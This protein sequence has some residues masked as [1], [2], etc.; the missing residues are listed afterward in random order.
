MS[1]LLC[2]SLIFNMFLYCEQPK[3]MSPEDVKQAKQRIN[4]MKK[5]VAEKMDT[6]MIASQPSAVYDKYKAKPVQKLNLIEPVKSRVYGKKTA[7]NKIVVLSDFACGHCIT[8][9]KELKARID[10]N[11]DLVN[12]TYVFYPLDRVC[13]PYSK[14][15]LSDYS[16]ISTKLALCAEKQGKVWKAMDFLYENQRLGNAKDVKTIQ[17]Q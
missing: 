4:E 10:E 8:A 17:A 11:K 6:A 16:C 3:K 2:I 1:F 12:L 14:G 7:K 9:S 15:K 5:K 13:N